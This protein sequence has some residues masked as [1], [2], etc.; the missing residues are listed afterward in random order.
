MSLTPDKIALKR[1]T[2]DVIAGVGGVEAAANFC[3]VGKSK[4]SE[5]QTPQNEDSFAALDVIADLEPL[6]R[7]RPGW[8]HV[9][10]LFCRANGGAF[11]ELPQAQSAGH[12]LAGCAAAHAKEASEVTARLFEATRNGPLTPAVIDQFEL[13][14]EAREAVEASVQLLAMIQAIKGGGE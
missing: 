3:R 11:V 1:A 5:N 14:R 6:A 13:E 9:T 8:P 2:A 7:A 4:L 12:D 10:R